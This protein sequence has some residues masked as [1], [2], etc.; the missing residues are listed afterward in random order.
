MPVFHNIQR[1]DTRW[2]N[3]HKTWYNYLLRLSVRFWAGSYNGPPVAVASS[4]PP[5]WS[6]TWTYHYN[7]T[8]APQRWGGPSRSI[9]MLH[10][11][12]TDQIYGVKIRH[13]LKRCQRGRLHKGQ[14]IQTETF[15]DDLDICSHDNGVLE[16]EP[17]NICKLGSE[18]T[19]GV[20]ALSFSGKTIL[21][22]NNKNT[23][24]GC[25]VLLA[26]QSKCLCATAGLPTVELSGWAWSLEAVVNNT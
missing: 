8:A 25:L 23:A 22:R 12:Q 3:E 15:C 10:C 18:W 26:L 7:F 14:F 2:S 1:S 9:W 13:T 21:W 24:S 5:G 20:A 11:I 16:T 4:R 17:A 6:D 19:L